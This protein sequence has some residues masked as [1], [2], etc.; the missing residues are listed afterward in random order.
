M[1]EGDFANNAFDGEGKFYTTD[2][3]IYNCLFKDGKSIKN[4]D[5]N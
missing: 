5:N 2:G 1:Y 4:L 3:N